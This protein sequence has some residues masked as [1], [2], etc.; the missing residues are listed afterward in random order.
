MRVL[1]TGSEGC[2]G[3]WV[4]KNL[5]DRGVDV[6]AYDLTG[7]LHRLS[8]IAP[9]SASARI[10]VQT[11]AIEDTVRIKNL[12]READITHIVHLAAVLM[13]Y[14]QRE[15]V[16]GGLIN[17][18]G[19]LNVFEA[20]R[21][22]GRPVRVVY[23]SSSAVWGPPEQYPDRPLTEED[24]PKPT[25]HYGVFKQANEASARAFYLSDGI[26]SVGLRPWTVYG[27]GRDTGL[28]A[29]PTLAM[30]A[31]ALRRPYQIRLSGRMDLQYVEDVAEAFV[32]CLLAPLE[33]A[34]VFNLAGEVVSMEE[35]IALLDRLR[36]GARELI[37]ASGPTVP[38]ACWMEDG[39]L[40][41]AVPGL[42]K[43]PLEEGV[44]RTLE[45][46]ER[47]YQEGRLPL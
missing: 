43:T 36:P 34:H 33:G 28:T 14:C 35:F 47:L 31:V 21:D 15:P 19:T 1:V 38:V 9:A 23:A 32:R 7:D 8:L 2:I 26:S 44:R 3:A 22:A 11:G 41:K 13:P 24:L 25:T 16:R 42:P 29:D 39:A 4:V 30:K 20:A 46:F 5:L 10:N 40:R 27:V 17:V 12:V 37:S 18:I 6:V 45:C